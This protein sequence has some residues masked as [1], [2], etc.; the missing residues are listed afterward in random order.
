MKKL[1]AVFLLLA[2]STGAA[3]AKITLPEAEEIKLTSGLT[4][5]IVERHNLPLFSI[6]KSL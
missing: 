6:Q 2:F 5:K 1:I 4:V 3:V